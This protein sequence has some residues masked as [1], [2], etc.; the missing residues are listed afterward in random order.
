MT[1]RQQEVQPRQEVDI[2]VALI[3]IGKQ[4][5]VSHPKISFS[6]LLGV[7]LCLLG[8]GFAPSE[9]AIEMMDRKHHE[10]ETQLGHMLREA[11]ERVNVAESS[12]YN[13]KGWFFTCDAYC[14]KK[15]QS[16][17]R[18]VSHLKDLQQQYN[19]G[20]AEANANVGI[21]STY[22]VQQARSLFWRMFG[23]GKTFAKR[24][25]MW[26]TLF[27]GIGAMGR[28][29]GLAEFL[30]RMLV[31]MLFNFTVGLFGALVAFTFNLWSVIQSFGADLFTGA[32]FFAL[33]VIAAVSFSVSWLVGLY[34]AAAGTVYVIAK[35]SN[36]VRIEGNGQGHGRRNLMHEH[37]HRQ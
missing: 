37:T 35:S 33:A 11:Q 36:N 1:S 6:Y 15:R 26:D 31:N 3:D 12:Y 20:V 17:E 2:S 24:Q 28:D 21:F 34:G 4:F 23:H 32:A 25:T 8:T 27:V 16:Y 30:L 22:G 10:V 14:Q 9:Q 19:N 29:E 18:S 13:S 5:V 7:L